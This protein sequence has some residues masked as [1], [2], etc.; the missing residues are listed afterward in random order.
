MII[1]KININILIGFITVLSL[2]VG[3][4]TLQ[5]FAGKGFVPLNSLNIQILLVINLIFLSSFLG[6]LFVKFSKIFLIKKNKLEIGNKTKNRLLLYFIS[7]A[8]I[9]SIIVAIFSL[10]IFNFSIEKWFDK[11]INDVVNNSVEVAKRYLNE[12]QQSISKD[13]LL[14]ANDF[15][16]NKNTLISDKERFEKYIEAQARIRSINN[17]YIVSEKGDLIF[18]LPGYDKKNFSKPDKY[19]LSAANKG[20]PIIISSAYTNKTYGMVKLSNF[21][22]YYL[23]AVQNVNPQIVSNLKKTGEAYSYYIDIKNNIFSLQITF[24]IIYIIITLILIFISSIVSINLSNYF[25]TPLVSLFNASNKIKEGHYNFE[26]NE[27]NLDSDFAQFNQT[28][29]EMLTKIRSDQKKIS[30]SGRF[31]AWNIIAKKLAHEIKNPL[32]PIQLSLDTIR[33]KF[34]NQIVINKKNFDDHIEIINQQIAEINSLLKSFSDF[35]RMPSPSLKKNNIIEIINTS[36]NPYKKNYTNIDFVFENSAKNKFL[37]CDKNQIFRLITNLI[38][39]SVESVN[40]KNLDKDGKIIIRISEDLK[41]FHFEIIDNGIGFPQKNLNNLH[42]PYFTTKHNGSGLGL[43]IVGKIIHEHKGD[44]YF[45]NNQ[46]GG[47]TIKFTIKK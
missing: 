4:L 29:N 24:M 18:S 16:R 39:N 12:H 7:L 15:N 6:V 25:T 19:I 38:K 37:L 34:K 32:T 14:T 35:A 43:S 45:M 8:A 26:L 40:E 13:I 28:F 33:D 1:K 10:L 11:K 5:T 20:K 41:Y 44:F 31:E 23:Y 17:L 42:E 27:K 9:P 36:I 30:L 46:D 22:N 2:I 47:A 21:D 3:F